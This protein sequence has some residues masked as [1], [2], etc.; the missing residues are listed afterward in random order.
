[1]DK[2]S[3][4]HGN[5]NPNDELRC[6]QFKIDALNR[7][8]EVQEKT[9]IEQT[10]LLHEEILERKQAEEK[11]REAQSQ[12][13]ISEKLA[14]IGQLSAGVCHE[15]LNPLNILSLHIQMQ[16]KKKAQDSEYVAVLEKMR[17]EVHRIDKIVRNLMRF[18]R[19]D[20]FELKK[21]QIGTELD[22]VISMIE[23]EFK[24]DNII[25]VKDIDSGLPYLWA[26]ADELRQV[27][28]NIINNAKYAMNNGGVLTLSAKLETRKNIPVVQLKFKDT[29]PGI[30]KEH[31]DKIFDPFFTTK[32]QGE[33]TGMGLSVAHSIIEK[34]GGSVAV[35][36]REG[37]GTTFI[38]D[39]P[40]MQSEKKD[41]T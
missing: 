17:A 2:N 37:A 20:D 30:K 35:E 5:Q 6:L 40:I 8:L 31:L 29:G 26:D 25:L 33:G 19:K 39:L 3:P 14:G 9:V 18:A 22:S 41:R 28:L 21:I 4:R 12:L 10:T 1:M 38:I 7:L 36:S 27:I 34:H 13:I 16:L 32:P 15:I 11:L 23:N 24:T